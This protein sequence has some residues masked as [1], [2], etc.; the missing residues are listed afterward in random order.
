MLYVG[1]FFGKSLPKESISKLGIAKNTY[2]LI[3]SIETLIPFIDN[4]GEL[5]GMHSKPAF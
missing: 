5:R 4:Q 1:P 3:M 2:F